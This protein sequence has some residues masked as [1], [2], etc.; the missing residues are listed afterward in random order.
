MGVPIGH[1]LERNVTPARNI[2]IAKTGRPPGAYVRSLIPYFSSML[3]LGTLGTSI[4]YTVSGDFL[5]T[6][7][8]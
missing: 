4:A 7:K 6:I 5:T 2:P 3:F 1:L 8:I